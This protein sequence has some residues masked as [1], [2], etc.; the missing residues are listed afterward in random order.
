M[1]HVRKNRAV[2]P[3][4]MLAVI[5]TTV[6]ACSGIS[7]EGGNQVAATSGQHGGQHTGQHAM[8]RAA[9][10][11]QAGITQFGQQDWAGAT[12]AFHK[13]LAIEPGN[14]YANYD[15][16]VIAQRT[17]NPGQAVSYYNKALAGNATYTPAMFNEA[18]LLER[19]Q[20]RRAIA[21]YQKIVNINPKAS[22]AYLRMALVQAK[23]GDLTGAMANDAKAVS[24]DPALAKY[25]LRTAK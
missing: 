25:S 20:P 11:I 22:T 5:A 8:P 14:V 3:A 12:A 15:L 10:L 2:I 4:A 19:S 16:G 7:G 24:I 17:G 9:S 21:M 1:K 6:A 23:R 18:I 13:V